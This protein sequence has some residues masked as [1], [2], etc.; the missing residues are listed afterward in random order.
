MVLASNRREPLLRLYA[1]AVSWSARRRSPVRAVAVAVATWALVLASLRATVALPEA[2]PP[3]TGADL[4]SSVTAAVAWFEANL[5]PDGRWTY[6]YHVGRGEVGRGYSVVR[7]AGVLLSLYQAAAAEEDGALVLADA[8]LGFAQRQ[9]VAGPDWQALREGGRVPTGATALLVAAL[10]ERREVTGDRSFDDDLRAYGRFLVG[11]VEPSGSVLATWNPATA[12]P[13]PGEYSVFFTGEAFWALARL[14]TAF[15]DE[16]WDAPARRVGRYLATQRDE[17]ERRLPPVPD[18][19]AAYGVDELGRRWPW[20]AEEGG[21]SAEHGLGGALPSYA[22]RLAGLLATA[23]RFQ[24]KTGL[25]V[26]AKQLDGPARAAALGTSG[27]GLAALWRLTR[28]A[29]L[30]EPPTADLERRIRCTAGILAERQVTAAEAAAAGTP[31]LLRGAWL[32]HSETRMDDQ[33]H[34]L[35]A[36]LGAREVLAGRAHG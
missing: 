36:L 31:E 22:E 5:R 4:D 20:S 7:H 29:P 28:V 15:P 23:S 2:C 14:H 35:S 12:A 10:A 3:I 8:G 1:S 21:R 17:V 25:E 34:A 27:E 13:V 30:R 9:V 19:W 24:A 33:Q 26:V 6:R 16:G 18:H 11:Q 32:T